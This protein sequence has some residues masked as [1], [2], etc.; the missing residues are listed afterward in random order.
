MAHSISGSIEKQETVVVTDSE[1]ETRE[2]WRWKLGARRVVSSS[3]VARA[4]SGLL[5]QTGSEKIGDE[6]K[7]FLKGKT[8]RLFDVL[9]ETEGSRERAA[10][11]VRRSVKGR[12]HGKG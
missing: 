12:I 3:R 1:F 4:I 7:N 11:L 9:V 10:E 2:G 8:E 5:E 6:E